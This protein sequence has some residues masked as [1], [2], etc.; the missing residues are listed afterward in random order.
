MLEESILDAFSMGSSAAETKSGPR[1]EILKSAMKKHCFIRDTSFN[2][3]DDENE[4]ETSSDLKKKSI[5]S[6]SISRINTRS[7]RDQ[8]KF[9]HGVFSKRKMESAERLKSSV[10]APTAHGHIICLGSIFCH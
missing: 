9:A 1:V 6:S 7:A 2:D 3:V 5:R 10:M 4:L 8:T